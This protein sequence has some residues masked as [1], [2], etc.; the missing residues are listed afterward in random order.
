T[1]GNSM[2]ADDKAA[3]ATNNRPTLSA[4]S[5]A[6]RTD[7]SG[8]VDFSYRGFDANNDRWSYEGLFLKNSDGT[9]IEISS[10]TADSA[11]SDP[12]YFCSTGSLQDF[13][14]NALNDIGQVYY[15]NV[16]VTFIISDG[17]D[18]SARLFSAFF[19]LD[20]LPPAGITGFKQ[21]GRDS[22][23]IQLQW[24][25][26]DDDSS[27][28]VTEH[29]FLKY[30][31]Y[32]ST[33][34]GVD[35]NSLSWGTVEQPALG[36]IDTRIANVGGLE[37]GMRYYL[38]LRAYDS[39]G[40]TFWAEE[41]VSA[42]TGAGPSSLI[43]VPVPAQSTSGDGLVSARLF[44]SHPDD[45]D[46]FV[47][48][49]YSTSGSGA[50]ASWHNATLSTAVAA[51]SSSGGFLPLAPPEV[52]NANY[53]QIGTEQNPVL[54]STGTVAL[55][56][57]WK[58]A[59]ELPGA[60]YE[61]VFLRALV[62][63]VYGITQLAAAVSEP[64]TVD[65]LKPVSSAARYSHGE[66]FYSSVNSA[67]LILFC[68]KIPSQISYENIFIS[69]SP[70]FP[71]DSSPAINLDE[72]EFDEASSSSTLYFNLSPVKWQQIALWGR[73]AVNLYIHLSSASL[74]D[75]AGNGLDE[76][77]MEVVWFKDTKPPAPE[78]Q[79]YAQ[80]ESDPA[81]FSGFKIQFNDEISGWAE[82]IGSL[83]S[84]YTSRTGP[85]TKVSFEDGITVSTSSSNIF[86]FYPSEKKHIDILNLGV[87]TLYLSL[88]ELAYDY[89]GNWMQSIIRENALSVPLTR[90]T[91][92][93]WVIDYSPDGVAREDPGN[94]E[95]WLRF[96]EA[97]YSNSVTAVNVILTKI[98]NAEGETVSENV[99]SA[100]NYI[101]SSCV[102]TISPYSILEYGCAYRLT[103]K[104]NIRD[105][106]L[107][108]MLSDFVVDF[109]TLFDLSAGVTLSTGPAVITVPA[110]VLSGSGRIEML[111]DDDNEKISAAF[112]RESA[113]A[114]PSH[115]RMVGG[116]VTL[117]LY[118][119]FDNVVS[120]TFASSV[121][122]SFSYEDSGADG[123]VDGLS[124][125]VRVESLAIYWLSEAT[126]WI[127]LP[128]SRI[129][130]TQKKVTADLWH[131]SSYALMGGPL[132]GISD[133]HPYPVPYKKSEDIGNGIIFS[134]PSG[135]DA[136]IEIYDIMGRLLE[137][138]SYT[139]ATASPPGLFTGWTDVTLPSGVYIYRIKSGE[140]EKRG[141]LVIIQ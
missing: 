66:E 38:K 110:G 99:L 86:W 74:R 20:T 39:F 2:G 1:F 138:F 47:N 108:H 79:F 102:I 29:N 58:S 50:G 80:N 77:S 129:D 126:S 104:D 92:A 96:N 60:L 82:D 7:G 127:K 125:P 68:N 42:I 30:V 21:K 105:M 15:N 35:E 135:S 100:I 88:G 4:V 53:F 136:E 59:E 116:V 18:E 27:I 26:N 67:E 25:L 6:Q 11:F 95:I 112:L 109:E 3:A 8:N 76:T 94:M 118:D 22:A 139:D 36:E 65:N 14:F 75:S 46:S 31:V 43:T 69:T 51:F 13:V 123:F 45:F 56:V 57:L 54:T 119:D 62:K 89:S 124:P 106:S 70:F 63:D 44:C 23:H 84:V 93:P 41:E 78:N 83:M 117:E 12:L 103:V 132:F 48:V 133:A 87:S 107:N 128:T 121:T 134:F 73:D 131:F 28:P 16:K 34:P 33:S 137:E 120:T 114:A 52:D 85:E 141:K 98:R 90:E 5:V 140:N 55:D 111:L 61:N 10:N 130:R 91:S 17:I 37:S 40:N 24:N 71:G 113:M 32:Y 64:F 101:S 115:R 122:L 19:E 81:K 72:S 49:Q 97:L 9:M